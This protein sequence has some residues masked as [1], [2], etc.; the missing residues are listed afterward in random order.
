[1]QTS[2]QFVPF[3][4]RV[5]PSFAERRAHR[6]TGPVGARCACEACRVSW[7]LSHGEPEEIE[8][9]LRG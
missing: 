9:E 6:Y 1:M 4:E 3:D 8:K 2:Q 5:P 7:S